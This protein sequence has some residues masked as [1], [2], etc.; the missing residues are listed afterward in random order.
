M[1]IADHIS[2]ILTVTGVVTGLV[3][4]QFFLPVAVLRLLSKIDMHDEAG[5]FFAR[6]WGLLA[7]VIGGLLVYSADHAEARGAIMLAAAVEKAGLVA[8]VLLHGRRPYTRGLRLAAGFDGV[9]VLIYAA[10]LLGLA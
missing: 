3:V 10:Y 7:F 8:L 2:T 1:I 9:C 6:H 5:L 4:L